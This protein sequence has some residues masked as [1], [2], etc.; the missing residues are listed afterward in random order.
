[1]KYY[2]Y[3]GLAY[4]IVTLTVLSIELLKIEGLLEAATDKYTI[5]KKELMS[6]G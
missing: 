3:L 1:M 6:H 2:F 5:F 4:I